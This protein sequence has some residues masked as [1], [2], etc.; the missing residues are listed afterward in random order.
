V[1][2]PCTLHCRPLWYLCERYTQDM[3]PLYSML[4]CCQYSVIIFLRVLFP[5]VVSCFLKKVCFVV[6][7]T[8]PNQLPVL[9]Y[10]RFL[11]TLFLA[12]GPQ[13]S[14]SQK[15]S[16]TES[17]HEPSSRRGALSCS[18]F[19]LAFCPAFIVRSCVLLLEKSRLVSVPTGFC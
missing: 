5:F 3:L 4:L 17:V 6:T 12:A 9:P 19:G 2:V 1:L 18:G 7:M 14:Q 15:K 11:H 10:R 16:W 13:P 8:N